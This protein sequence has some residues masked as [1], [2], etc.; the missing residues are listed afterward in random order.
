MLKKP[1]KDGVKDFLRITAGSAAL[2]IGNYFFK[3]P[4]KFV[5]GGVTGLS[6][7][8][9]ARVPTVSTA[10][11]NLIINALFLILG[12]VLL[13]RKFGIKTI[14]ATV[15][16]TASISILEKVYPM[17]APF[18]DELMLEF[19]ISIL[20]TAFGSAMLFHCEASSGGTDIIAMILKKYTGNDIGWMLMLSDVLVVL[21]AFF[22]F[23]I[24]T[25]LFS[26][27]GLLIKSL[28]IDTAVAQLN[29]SRMVSIICDK[30]DS[31]CD[32]I[33]CSLNKDATYH[34]A[35]GAYS[36]QK[37][38]IVICVLKPRQEIRLRR[39]IRD[40]VPGAFVLVSDSSLIFGKGFADFS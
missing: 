2:V 5:Y 24:R 22:V 10:T 30:P 15:L 40:N 23:D 9:G 31:V 26:S 12:F 38:F 18:T 36:H 39:Y 4:N 17:P 13:G 29:R 28:I 14:Y 21:A 3:F 19:S 7:L 11:V 33:I 6:V 16:M 37:K 35:T 32:Y 20:L 34:D 27:L 25:A 1:D 8:I